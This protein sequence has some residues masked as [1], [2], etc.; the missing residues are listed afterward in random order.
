MCYEP[1]YGMLPAGIIKLSLEFNLDF[2]SFTICTCS[3]NLV[4]N[5]TTLVLGMFA[6]LAVSVCDKLKASFYI[7]SLYT[8]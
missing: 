5:G 8:L 2:P 7:A 6:P 1:A 4:L 3:V